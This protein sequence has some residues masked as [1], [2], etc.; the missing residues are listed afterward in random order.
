MVDDEE[1]KQELQLV[2]RARRKERSRAHI[3]QQT[4]VF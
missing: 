3:P 1:M 2:E 4:E